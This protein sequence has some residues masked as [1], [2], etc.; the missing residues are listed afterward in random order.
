MMKNNLIKYLSFV[1]ARCDQVR[2]RPS[3]PHIG[4]GSFFL[5]ITAYFTGFFAGN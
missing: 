4:L 3:T 5:I 1:V 2:F